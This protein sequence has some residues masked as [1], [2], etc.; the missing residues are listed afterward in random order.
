MSNSATIKITNGPDRGKVFML[1]EDLVYVGKDPGNQVPLQDPELSDHHVT[2]VSKNGRY[3]IYTPVGDTVQVDG[4]DLPPEQWV[5]LPHS[6]RIKV[7]NRTAFQF[8]Q[9]TSSSGATYSSAE[10]PAGIPPNAADVEPD[11]YANRVEGRSKP[12]KN[13]R[14]GRKAQQ[15]RRG[16][17]KVARFV[18]GQGGDTLVSLGEDGNLPELELVEGPERRQVDKARPRQKN[19]MML[20]AALGASL[21]VSMSMLLFDPQPK[22]A[23]VSEKTIARREIVK[24]YGQPGDELRTYQDYL[25]RAARARSRGNIHRA[26]GEQSYYRYIIK[27]I[28]AEDN[29]NPYSDMDTQF[30]GLV[31]G[32]SAKDKELR[33]ILTVLTSP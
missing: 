29:T 13:Q 27:L 7:S 28:D 10:P 31:T 11:P 14:K 32:T 30:K 26:N 23:T 8:E 22:G 12:R 24:F 1:E 16:E 33:E 18:A 20:Y 21:V 3:A 17:R 25:R 19:P 6:A 2:I 15:Q 5:W 9:K 4:S